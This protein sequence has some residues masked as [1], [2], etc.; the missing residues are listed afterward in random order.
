MRA[1][2]RMSALKASRIKEPGLHAD[3]GGLYLQVGRGDARSWIFRYTAGG[4]ERQMGLGPAHTV[5]L[6]EARDMA[7]E[8]RKVRL[9]GVDPIEARKAA[10]ETARR[11]RASAVT[12][13]QAVSEYI[14]LNK[15]GW[16]NDK[17]AAQWTSTLKTYAEP[18]IG[19]LPVASIDAN[20]ILRV[21]EPIWI[22]KA[23]TAS[24]VRGRM[25]AVLD[26]STVRGQRTGDNPARWRGNLE[27]LLPAKSK[28][29]KVTHHAAI[30]RADLPKFMAQLSQQVGTAA[31]AL[32]F[33]VLT[34]TRTSE[35]LG[36]RWEEIDLQAEIWTIPADRM[37]AGKEH[38][39]ALSERALA[40]LKP[41]AAVRTSEWLFPGEGKTDGPLSNMAMLKV[42]K[43]MNR[44]DLT[45]H[46]FRST[47]RDWAAETT[48]TPG[49]VVEMALAHTIASKVEAAYRRG[50]LLEKRRRLMKAW[51]QYCASHTATAT[52]KAPKS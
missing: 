12:F 21:L 19:A 25:E 1:L 16:R 5:S 43:R 2:H 41:L 9:K 13:S 38:K 40:V 44:A 50:D 47:F 45:T 11:E 17:H 15:A 49:E 14:R 23:E 28:V 32:E 42:L 26:W 36:A 24:R 10:Q 7:L 51:G 46:G 31:R 29:R 37:K 52:Q 6:A 39:V 48:S 4:R 18:I 27:M 8:L 22:D 20:D 30:D 33:T 34:A 3:G 35:V